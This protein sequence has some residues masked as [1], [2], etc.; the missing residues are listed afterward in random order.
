MF[1]GLFDRL[2]IP[3]YLAGSVGLFAVL[4]VPAFD[5]TMSVGSTVPFIL[6]WLI[7]YLLT[8]AA[9]FVRQIKPSKGDF[10]VL[11]FPLYFM[12]SSFWSLQPEKTLT[13]SAV[14]FCNAAFATYF[15]HRIK[16]ENAPWLIMWVITVLCFL[17]LL[18][19][20][21]GV[22]AI[23]YYDIHQRLTILG[24]SPI[25]GFFFHKIS[26][27]FY[28]GLAALLCLIMLRGYSRIGVLFLLA[29]FIALTGSASGLALLTGSLL[30]YIAI[31]CMLRLRLSR[32]WFIISI[33]LFIFAFVLSFHILTEYILPLLDRDPTLTGRTILWDWGLDAS[34]KKFFSGWGYL[35]YNG[36][37]VARADSIAFRGSLTSVTPHFHNSYVQYLVDAG[38][39]F[40]SIFIFLHFYVLV[41]WYKASLRTTTPEHMALVCALI[42]IMIGSF[43]GYISGRYNDLS[44]ILIFYLLGLPSSRHSTAKIKNSLLRQTQKQQA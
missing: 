33:V 44:T 26:A 12:F 24:T 42:Y 21:L 13:Y 22:E 43:F 9:L 38:W 40:G 29:L 1:K 23:N 16:A 14:L 35:S 6:T 31:R 27:G 20:I 25:R 10:L 15:H 7:L 4:F 36:T 19:Y 17:S 39:I 8:F 28:A 30:I 11:L 34:Y 37:D 32:A 18:A 3:T 41:A 2:F 5:D